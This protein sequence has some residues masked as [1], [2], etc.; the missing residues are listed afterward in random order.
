MAPELLAE[1]PYDHLADIWSLGCIIYESVAGQAP[2]CTTSILQLIRLIKKETIKWPTF[3]SEPC[4]TFLKGLLQKDPNQRMSW[5]QILSHPF[6]QGHIIILNENIPSSPF[7]KSLTDSQNLMKQKQT[8]GFLLSVP[9]FIPTNLDK[10]HAIPISIRNSTEFTSSRDSTK[11][12]LYSDRGNGTDESSGDIS[13][14]YHKQEDQN[15]IHKLMDN[16]QLNKIVFVE[17]NNNLIVNRLYD[18]F[19]AKGQA[20]NSWNAAQ[21]A[22]PYYWNANQIGN[23]FNNFCVNEHNLQN[24]FNPQPAMVN[25]VTSSYDSMSSVS[26]FASI[27]KKKCKITK[28]SKLE[29][30]KLNQNLEHFTM[31]LTGQ[32]PES[33]TQH[34]K[35]SHLFKVPQSKEKLPINGS[36]PN[37]VLDDGYSVPLEN[38]EWISFLKRVMKQ[39]TDGDFLAFVH[40]DLVSIILTP[41]RNPT[42]SCQVIE[43]A[44][45]VLCLP[46]VVCKV[47]KLLTDIRKVYADVK[48]VPN[49]IYA[50]KLLC[51]KTLRASTTGSSINFQML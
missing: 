39:I 11:A 27:P 38:D 25:C 33:T 6:V 40:H 23:Q 24:Y 44:A 45:Q 51:S 28:N 2:F 10:N 32:Q 14:K 15:T 34:S 48:A 42:A 22:N 20:M 46:L 36:I 47:P 1:K 5:P 26:T 7:T 8:E 35:D 31:R 41:M 9:P 12:L 49:L 37:L 17:G 16:L 13:T 21:I 29:K 50:S 18:N 30:K 43:N 3:V 19:P 4:M